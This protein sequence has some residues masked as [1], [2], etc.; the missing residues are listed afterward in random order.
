MTVC[1]SHVLNMI[2]HQSANLV[3][4]PFGDCQTFGHQEIPLFLEAPDDA[5]KNLCPSNSL[6]DT[7]LL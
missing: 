4:T 5:F 3:S 6:A 2:T 7:S 1:V